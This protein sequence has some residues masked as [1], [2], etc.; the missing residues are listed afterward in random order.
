MQSDDL[1]TLTQPEQHSK[2]CQV[3]RDAQRDI[4]R[5]MDE[6]DISHLSALGGIEAV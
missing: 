4:R 2:A 5:D 1:G 6:F 3:C